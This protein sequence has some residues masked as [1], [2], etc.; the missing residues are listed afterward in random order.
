MGHTNDNNV[1]AGNQFFFCDKSRVLGIFVRII[2]IGSM[3]T[4]NLAKF[5][6]KRIPHIIN[7]SLES[8]M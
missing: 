4:E 3:K 2:D 8:Q 1:T 6:R 5:V 7:I